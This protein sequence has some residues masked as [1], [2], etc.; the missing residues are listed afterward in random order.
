MERIDDGLPFF[1]DGTIIVNTSLFFLYNRKNH[2]NTSGDWEVF[3]DQS[4]FAQ[5]LNFFGEIEMGIEYRL[6][7]RFKVRSTIN[8]QHALVPTNLNLKT[9][10]YLYSGGIGLGL[11]FTPHK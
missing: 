6:N 5:S 11:V 1:P 4:F 9:K 7:S 2:V 3:K 10:E 8:F